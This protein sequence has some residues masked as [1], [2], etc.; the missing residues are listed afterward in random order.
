MYS[1]FDHTKA[2]QKYWNYRYALRGDDID[3][4]FPKWEPGFLEVGLGNGY[5]LPMRYRQI[6]KHN[7]KWIIDN[8]SRD[9]NISSD[10][11]LDFN[12]FNIDKNQI[13]TKHGLCLWTDAP[14]DL[15]QYLGV[16][17]TEFALFKQNENTPF[18][19]ESIQKNLLELYYA[20]AA[21]DRLDINSHV[22]YNASHHWGDGFFIRDDVPYNFALDGKF[23]NAIEKD[24]RYLQNSRST[25]YKGN[26]FQLVNSSW[27]NHSY[28]NQGNHNCDGFFNLPPNQYGN[29]NLTFGDPMS[30]DQLIKLLIGLVLVRKFVHG[31]ETINTPTGIKTAND[32]NKQAY[33]FIDRAI[34]YLKINCFLIKNPY[35]G[36]Q[37]CRGGEAIFYR[38]PLVNIYD[39]WASGDSYPFW[40]CFASSTLS[41]PFW[42]GIQDFY[43]NAMNSV[44]NNLLNALNN[45]INNVL[46]SPTLMIYHFALAVVSNPLYNSTNDWTHEMSAMLMAMSDNQ[47]SF[48]SLTHKLSKNLYEKNWNDYEYQNNAYLSDMQ[49]IL[50]NSIPQTPQSYLENF[51]MRENF[52]CEHETRKFIDRGSIG[53]YE[54]NGLN[55]MLAFNIYCLQNRGFYKFFDIANGSIDKLPNLYDRKVS[56]TFPKTVSL[57]I[58]NSNINGWGNGG[59]STYTLTYGTRSNPVSI[60]AANSIIVRNTVFEPNSKG[61]IIA[62]RV[63]LQPGFKADYG[64]FCEVRYDRMNCNG[65]PAT[66]YASGNNN[67]TKVPSALEIPNVPLEN[68]SLLIDNIHSSNQAIYMYP[69][70]AKD[71]FEFILKVK[72]KYKV[73]VSITNLLG[74]IMLDK[75]MNLE[76]F[77]ILESY[78]LDISNLNSGTYLVNFFIDDFSSTQKLLIQK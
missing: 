15:G 31:N 22:V 40:N 71:Y 33:D 4:S 28:N 11:R 38:Q 20:L 36:D 59:T 73:K 65:T 66:M 67:S 58:V 51:L 72:P 10:H 7:S 46:L 69:N 12:I 50:Y 76:E 18:N 45:S 35:N 68:K 70:P 6:Q 48:G 56:G 44:S 17:A 13:G 29:S 63:D 61:E 47:R 53:Y 43:E 26:S 24:P 34:W 75:G 14:T 60:Q 77:E 1:Q 8:V 37:V 5:S 78:R 39:R 19:Q 42:S 27:V 16:L 21:A 9:P 55:Y 54:R 3:P 25:Y 2:L 57:N 62:P 49:Q 32:L 41:H 64:A 30:Q 52:E 74:E 23:G